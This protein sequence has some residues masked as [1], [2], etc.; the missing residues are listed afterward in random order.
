MLGLIALWGIL[1]GSFSGLS[2]T[3]TLISGIIG[4][5]SSGYTLWSTFFQK[6]SKYTEIKEKTD[7]IINASI[8]ICDRLGL[9]PE[10]VEYLI[11]LLAK[12]SKVPSLLIV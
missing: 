1:S 9:S 3:V 10:D 6:I 4:T 7:E 11:K 12:S 5:A 2:G 8:S